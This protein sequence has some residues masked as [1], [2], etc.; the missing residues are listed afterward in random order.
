MLY[1]VI[2]VHPLQGL[3]LRKPFLFRGESGAGSQQ[4]DHVFR[5]AL[6]EYGEIG[7]VPH[8]ACVFP[9]G[10][11]RKRVESAAGDALSAFV[12]A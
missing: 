8:F 5:I 6:V 3:L 4:I 12:Q 9:Q 2:T 1:E 7:S 11:V 10:E